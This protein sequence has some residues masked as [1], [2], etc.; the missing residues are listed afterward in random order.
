MPASDTSSGAQRLRFKALPC[1]RQR[2]IRLA[3]GWILFSSPGG[4]WHPGRQ[5]Y[6]GVGLRRAGIQH[7][8]SE[9]DG[10]FQ[11]LHPPG[12]LA[13]SS[14]R[15]QGAS[16]VGAGARN[17]LGHRGAPHCATYAGGI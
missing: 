12:Q 8:G 7:H 16:F 5:A 17:L 2:E 10:V 14:D 6:H 3:L 13:A 9:E 4:I 1:V 15:C 11:E